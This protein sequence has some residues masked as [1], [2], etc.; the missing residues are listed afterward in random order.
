[1][2][3][4]MLLLIANWCLVLQ[5]SQTP[6]PIHSLQTFGHDDLEIS[7][8][9]QPIRIGPISL[10]HWHHN[11]DFRLASKC[12]KYH[13]LLTLLLSGQVETNPGPSSG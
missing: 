11:H 2:F 12:G 10:V 6:P 3:S 13:I 4:Y 7:L 5:P 9:P 1:M 8:V